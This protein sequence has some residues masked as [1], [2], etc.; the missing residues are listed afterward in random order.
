MDDIYQSSIRTIAVALSPAG[1]DAG[2]IPA[3]RE[4]AIRLEG[5]TEVNLDIDPVV[6]ILDDPTRGG[7]HRQVRI[8]AFRIVEEAVAYALRHALARE[9]DVRVSSRL[10][11]TSAVLILQVRNATD[12]TITITEG[13]GL[14]RMRARTESVGGSLE[15]RAQGDA[16]EVIAHLPLMRQDEGRFLP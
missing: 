9:V 12:G 5:A 13:E 4:L 15:V 8:A 10:D 6:T 14:R 16:V 2:L 11:G 7:I 1:L 3:L